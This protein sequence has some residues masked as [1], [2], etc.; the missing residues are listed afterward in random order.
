MQANKAKTGQCLFEHCFGR[1]R[2]LE[3]KPVTAQSILPLNALERLE[4]WQNFYRLPPT[5]QDPNG[6]RRIVRYL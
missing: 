6:P 2:T 5:V 1:K 4:S 3:N